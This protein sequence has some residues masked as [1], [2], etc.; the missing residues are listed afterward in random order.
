MDTT[1]K[2]NPF[3]YHETDYYVACVGVNGGTDNSDIRE[4]F[5][6]FVHYLITAI[7][8]GATEDILIY[9]IVYNARHSIVTLYDPANAYLVDYFFDAD[10]DAFKYETDHDGNFHMIKHG[11]SQLV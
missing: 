3:E 4:G 5:K 2:N 6:K 10:G 9:P 11:I 7:K 8:E 1:V